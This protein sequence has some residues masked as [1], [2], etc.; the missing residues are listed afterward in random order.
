MADNRYICIHGHFYQP[1][2]ENAWLEVIEIQDSAHPYHDWNERISAEC[3][4]PNTAS[5]IL[6]KVGGVIKNI[7]NNYSRISFNFGPTL[8]SWMELYDKDTY[9]AVLDADKESIKNFEGHGSAMAQVFNHMIL[10]LA[11]RRDKETQVIWGIRD[12]ERRFKRKPEGM[13]LAESAVDTESL[14]ILAEQGILFTVLAPRQAKA[15]RKIGEPEWNSVND[16]TVDTRKAYRCNLPSGKSITLFFYDGNIAQGVAFNGL[17]Y[18]GRQFAER[19]FKGFNDDD[20]SPQLVNIATDGETYGHHHKSGDMALAFCLDY[21]EKNEGVTLTNY[22]AFMARFA[23]VHEAQII[24]NSSWSCVHGVERWRSNCGCN[25][26]K[27]GYTQTWRK[28]LRE[29][30]DWLRDTLAEIFEHEGSKLFRDPWESRNEYIKVILRRSEET[31]KRFIK[32]HAVADVD[33]NKALRLMELQRHAMLMYT[34]C[35]WFFDEISGIE[36]VQVI[37]YACRAI[38]LSKQLIDQDLEAE[39]LT[40]LEQAPSNVA[41]YKN[42][43]NVYRKLVLPSKTN[44]TRVGMHYAVSSIFEEEPENLPLFN[45]KASNEFFVKK[46]AGEQKLVLGITKVQSLVTRSEK[47][48]SFAVIYLGKH[49]LIG[50]LSLDIEL[51]KFASMQFRMVDAFEDG[52]LGD[53]IS[54]MQT[55]FGPEKYSIWSLFKEEKRKI[56]D[57]IARQG[58]E[59]IE[60]S[61]RRTYNRD[62]PLVNALSNNDIPIPN[63]YKTTFEYILNADL[64]K[65]FQPE[66]INIKTLERI[67]GEL[68]RW[69]LKIEDPGKVERIA[70]ESIYKELQRVTTERDNVKRIQRLNRL[71]P[72]L[73]KF[74]LEPNLYL[75]QNLYFQMSLEHKEG[76]GTVLS[77]EWLEQFSVL[78]DNL[79]VKVE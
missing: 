35:G 74:K 34:S 42:G 69:S 20:H 12:F 70:G 48:F 13:W 11:N 56:L 5:R 1:P 33:V 61:L 41:E 21:I 24:E 52:R 17:L 18:D 79:G 71:F 10:P 3:Y 7:S 19:I 23:P 36:T 63:A 15:T 31:V 47:R 78:G 50:N 72:I 62:Y 49:D 55:Y 40:R 73:E 59:D 8:L 66:R 6:D 60:S 77:P 53:V 2:R 4:A 46:E 38:Q 75:S 14:E 28:P 22:G 64:L 68:A 27:A 43:A 65:C 26:G 9:K 44:L 51:D 39:F 45:Y 58:L 16:Q 54:I 37:Q 32:G 30:L 25:G 76:K 29:S 67:V 57:T